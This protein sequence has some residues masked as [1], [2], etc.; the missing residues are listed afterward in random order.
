[1][2]AWES[3]FVQSPAN[4]SYYDEGALLYL[5]WNWSKETWLQNRLTEMRRHLLAVSQKTM[6]RTGPSAELRASCA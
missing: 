5:T 1:M 4:E 2:N 3:M 6:K